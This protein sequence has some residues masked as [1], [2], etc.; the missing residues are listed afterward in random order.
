MTTVR[1]ANEDVLAL[2]T[3]YMHTDSEQFNAVIGEVNQSVDRHKATVMGLFALINSLIDELARKDG[4]TEGDVLGVI[5]YQ[6]IQALERDPEWAEQ[7]LPIGEDV[8]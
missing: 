4:V 2:V 6:T 3:A 5:C 1:Q 8:E 7:E